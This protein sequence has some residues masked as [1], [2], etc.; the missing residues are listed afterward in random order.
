MNATK[1]CEFSLEMDPS[2]VRP[3]GDMVVFYWRLV[4]EHEAEDQT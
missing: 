2:S 4:E 1:D 3:S